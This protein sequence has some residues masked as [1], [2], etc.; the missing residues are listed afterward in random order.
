MKRNSP[1]CLGFWRSILCILLLPFLLLLLVLV[2][3]WHDIEDDVANNAKQSLAAADITWA[4]IETF[5]Q[6]RTAIITGTAP[7]QEE[8][9]LAYELVKNAE[10]VH[11]AEFDFSQIK[12][13]PKSPPYLKAI[14]T[15]DSIVLR[16]KSPDQSSIDQLILSAE[17]VFG[18][19]KVLN[20]MSIDNNISPLPA[21]DGLFSALV[22]KGNN[23]TFIAS[24]IDNELMLD[25]QV[26]DS[27]QKNLYEAEFRRI[28][29][30]EINNQL[31]VVLP[32]IKKDVCLELVNELLSKGKINFETGKATIEESSFTLLQDIADI[33][34]RCPKSNFE[35]AGHTDST[36]NLEFNMTLS[37]QRSQSVV[38]HLAS[39]GLKAERFTAQ[40]YGP[41]QPI[42]DNGTEEGREQNRRIEFVL[43][44]DENDDAQEQ[45][46]TN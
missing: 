28:V 8:A 5:N 35:I 42:A 37:Q 23:E 29:D 25:G 31:N 43:I 27:D 13:V 9:E 22:G 38:D 10:G 6:G 21:Y 11:K 15:H 39:L 20:K 36:G 26:I 7:T 12:I 2:F 30:L 44:D 4:S 19:G 32:P 41:N 14:V 33:A 24:F 3:D 18:K 40:G 17:A 34:I 1:F 45:D 16:G 46:S